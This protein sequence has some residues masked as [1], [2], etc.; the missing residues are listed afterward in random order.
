[1]D[2]LALLT[3]G[4]FLGI[5]HATDADHV[6]A[7]AT[8]VHRERT[9]GAALVLGARWGLGHSVTILIVG[10]A[11]LLGGVV[12]P[13]RVGLSLEMAV[14][15]MLILLGALNLRAR[16]VRPSPEG[17]PAA[18]VG[19]RPLAIG[20]VHGLAGSA[21]LAL[22][23]LTTIRDRVWALVYLTLF[24]AGTVIGMMSMTLLLMLPL[25]LASRRL[26]TLE[27]R[28]T[29]LTGTISLVVGL[30]LAYRLGI[31]DGLCTGAPH[32]TPS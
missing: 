2:P 9:A 27:H 10:G 7:V 13:P 26:G 21:A 14:A 18:G 11:I 32:W 20:I 6:I 24:G 15:V 4:F 22:L 1:V 31:G 8:L 16:P 28:L 25:S 12:V 29:R 30:V 17:P 19:W 3:L 5:R 23:V